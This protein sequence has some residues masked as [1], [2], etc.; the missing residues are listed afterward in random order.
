[1]P[2]RKTPEQTQQWLTGA[3]KAIAAAIAIATSGDDKDRRD[4]LHVQFD[5]LAMAA[6]TDGE[7]EYLGFAYALAAMTWHAASLS[8]QPALLS[9]PSEPVE[10]QRLLHL[11]QLSPNLPGF[12]KAV[13]YPDN[14]EPVGIDVM[15]R[16]CVQQLRGEL[17]NWHEDMPRWTFLGTVAALVTRG[18]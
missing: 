14:R 7:S 5:R 1:M 4:E 15:M 2:Q 6:K 12:I 17:D 3:H 13:S 10:V 18:A 8:G 16:A 11:A 9:N